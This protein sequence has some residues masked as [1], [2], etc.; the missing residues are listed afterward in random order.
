MCNAVN[1]ICEEVACTDIAD[2]IT[3][4]ATCAAALAAI[5][6]FFV[7]RKQLNKI[8]YTDSSRFLMELRDSFSEKR[9]WKV[10]CDIKENRVDS[11]YINERNAEI[12]DYLGLFEICEEMIANGSL[13]KVIFKKLYYFRLEC[14]MDCAPLVEMIISGISY[15]SNLI[16]L[17]KRFP[18]L[19]EDYYE[20][21][22]QILFWEQ[23]EDE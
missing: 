18:E 3:A 10:H 20:T 2:W 14:I 17:F 11:N 21:P 15:W 1:C 9:R 7:A 16:K 4:I 13:D 8:R 5:L 22:E 6:T 12:N 23:I 19:K